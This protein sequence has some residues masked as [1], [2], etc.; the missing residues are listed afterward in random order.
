MKVVILCGGQ[1]TRLREET[2]YR[3]KPLVD[4][5]GKPILWH[6]MKMYA[7]YGHQDFVLCLGYRGQ[8]IK[9][10]FLNYD[11][12]NNDFT[13][14][15]GNQDRVQYHGAHLEKDFCVTLAET[16]QDSMTGSRVKQVERF[17]EGDRFMVTYGDGVSDVDI[18]KL[19]KF[20]ESHGKLATITT[21]RPFSR[22]GILDLAENGQVRAFSEK[23]QMEGWASAGFFVFERAVFDFLSV[24]P[25]CILERA[26]LEKLAAL[27][28]LMAY[29]HDGF[30]FAMD[31]YREYLYLNELWAK[32]QA[33]WAVWRKR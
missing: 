21:M 22:F 32:N 11:A 14:C 27:G 10:Y 29:Q 25:S 3:P 16:G 20:H 24:D 1:G 31:T 13:I 12:M 18:A 23:P 15:L 17:V 6:I 7:H 2:E 19:L 28:Q 4:V 26:P 33:P 30:F 5:G 9:E 8:M